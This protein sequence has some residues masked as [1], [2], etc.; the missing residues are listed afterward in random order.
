[1]YIDGGQVMRINIKM[2]K[3]SIVSIVISIILM[4]FCTYLFVFGKQKFDEVKLS[5]QKYQVCERA[6][7]E[8]E[9]ASDYL[10]E[11]ARLYVQTK[12]VKYMHLYFKEV[13]ETKTRQ[14]ALRSL[15]R[16]NIDT[17]EI[18]GALTASDDLS[19]TEEY[20][21]K[22][23]FET[24]PSGKMP[25]ALQSLPI[26]QEDENLDIDQKQE[27]AK[28]LVFNT[29]YQSMRT[30]IKH[31]VNRYMNKLIEQ[32]KDEQ[33]RSEAIFTD[34]YTKIVVNV[35]IFFIL[36]LM[37]GYVIIRHILNPLLVY[38]EKIKTNELFPEVGIAELKNMAKIYNKVYQENE[39]TKKLIR[40]EAEH[41][42]LTDLLNRKTFDKMLKIYSTSDSSFALIL[43]DVDIFKSVNDTYG[44]AVGDEILKKVA[45]L[46][47]QEFRTIDH[48]CR[49]GGDEFAVIMVE[50]NESLKYTI[51]EKIIRMNQILENPKDG[52]PKVSLS[53][54]IAF[55]NRKNPEGTLFEDADKA[56]YKTKENG[57]SGYSFY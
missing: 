16:Q 34:V 17:T 3:V 48:I 56:L 57:K 50:M 46:L 19:K 26:R 32:T 43:I 21:I 29:Q 1:M 30:K 37:I 53:V 12:D 20:A 23:V 45:C 44:H 54:G 35:T 9:S 18:K 40:H 14:K 27:R 39:E 11:Q 41:D 10:T 55:S 28:D 13:N 5:N 7:N 33:N 6:A 15:Q 52:L 51:E 4:V 49:I 25:K 38:N 22:L 8:F 47:K 42:G 31:Q 24:N 36:V 2:K